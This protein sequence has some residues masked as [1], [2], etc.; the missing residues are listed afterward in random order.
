MMKALLL[1]VAFFAHA[2]DTAPALAN[3]QCRLVPDTRAKKRREKQTEEGQ[4]SGSGRR[5]SR[6]S[7]INDAPSA[8]T[9][10][11]R[12]KIALNETP[13]PIEQGGDHP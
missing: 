7:A 3:Y 5:G 12:K 4:G 6:G 13:T 11:E 10:G 1:L 9:R 2:D 8:H